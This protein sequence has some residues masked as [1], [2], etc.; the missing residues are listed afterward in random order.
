MFSVMELESQTQLDRKQLDRKNR[1]RRKISSR[2][3]PRSHK[4]RNQP[5]SKHQNDQSP[6]NKMITSQCFLNR[7]GR[8]VCKVENTQ[9]WRKNL[10]EAIETRNALR[11]QST[12]IDR[13]IKKLR[14]SKKIQPIFKPGYIPCKCLPK[15]SFKKDLEEKRLKYREGKMR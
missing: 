5:V 2:K 3:N 4:N 15:S 1:N 12:Q 10:N 14:E 6:N 7:E 11:K 13:V 8:I 9:A